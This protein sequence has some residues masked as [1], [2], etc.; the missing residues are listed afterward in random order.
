MS[1]FVPFLLFAG[2]LTALAGG[3]KPKPAAATKAAKAVAAAKKKDWQTAVANALASG[4][5]QAV[6]RV[7]DALKDA[8]KASIAKSMSEGVEALR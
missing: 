6:K 2:A 5:S 7:S 8:G 1:P 4:D 3:K